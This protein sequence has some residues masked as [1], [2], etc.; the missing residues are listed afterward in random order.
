MRTFLLVCLIFCM[1]SCGTFPGMSNIEASARDKSIV[2]PHIR[3]T[4][5][6]IPITEGLIKQSL[7]PRYIY[8]VEPHDI[9][10]ITVWRHT[11]FNP[12]PQF[13]ALSGTIA[14]QAS[15]QPGYLIDHNGYIFFPL[16]GNIHV[17]G[18]TVGQV[19]ELLT[20]R[21]SKYIVN[22]QISVRVADFRSKKIYIL[23]EIMRPGLLPL[24]DQVMSITDAITLAGSFNIKSADTRH[25][26]VIRGN[27]L[28]PRI[29]WLDARTPDAL[30]L[31]ERF[32][33]QPND[34]VYVSTALVTR[35]NRFIDQ[36]LPTLNQIIFFNQVFGR[37]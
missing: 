22:P 37:R 14:S 16:V 8:H 26:Y 1:C 3:V 12:P 4:P 13:V 35:W 24:N 19:R 17:A 2:V 29:Y 10:S 5:V 34:I 15:G 31:G 27:Y 11:E 9:L 32:Q 28:Q 36:L 20:K 18:K 7:A 25:I 6:V 33:L 21:L 30:I 23:G